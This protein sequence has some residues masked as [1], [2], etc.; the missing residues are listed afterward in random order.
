MKFGTLLVFIILS[1]SLFSQSFNMVTDIQIA[2]K[3]SEYGESIVFQDNLY[4]VGYKNAVGYCLFKT[5]GEARPSMVYNFGEIKITN[6]AQNSNYLVFLK[7]DE[8]W[9]TDGTTLGTE[10]VL[11]LLFPFSNRFLFQNDQALFITNLASGFQ[12]INRLDLTSNDTL[13]L[14]STQNLRSVKAIGEIDE[15]TFYAGYFGDFGYE[16]F[17]NSVGSDSL[18]LLKDISPGIANG[19]DGNTHMAKFDNKIFFIGKSIEYGNE[20][21]VTN[22]TEAGTYMLKDLYSG[23]GS[24]N[25]I[26]SQMFSVNNGIVF[27]ASN[28]I[29][30]SDGTVEGT[31]L[32]A[33]INVPIGAW[34]KGGDRIFINTG[35]NSNSY[36][37]IASAAGTY[38]KRMG[39]RISEITF[40]ENKYIYSSLNESPKG[41]ELFKFEEGTVSLLENIN[42]EPNGRIGSSQN[43]SFP[44]QFREVNGNLL[45]L[46][47]D[48]FNGTEL[49][50]TKNDSTYLFFELNKD[51]IQTPSSEPTGFFE[52][53]GFIYF[54]AFEKE[55]TVK[56][57]FKTNPEN[58]ETVKVLETANPIDQIVLLNNRIYINASYER[59][60]SDIGGDSFSA[61]D[62]SNVLYAASNIKKD[63]VFST[64]NTISKISPDLQVTH[65][66]TFEAGNEVTKGS[67]YLVNAQGNY[68]VAAE[69]NA[70]GRELYKLNLETLSIELVKDISAGG[71][72]TNIID[73]KAFNSNVLFV[74]ELDYYTRE[75]WFSDG[76]ELGTNRIGTYSYGYGAPISLENNAILG[77]FFYFSANFSNMGFELLKTD[78]TF[79]NTVLVSD[80]A[81]GECSSSDPGNFF[82][83]NGDLFFEAR[84]GCNFRLFKINQN[85]PESIIS[86]S[87]KPYLSFTYLPWDVRTIGKMDSRNVIFN[88]SDGSQGVSG[89]ELWVSDGTKEGTKL[90]YDLR[91]GPGNSNPSGFFRFENKMFFSANANSKGFE[92]WVLTLPNCPDDLLI[93]SNLTTDLISNSNYSTVIESKLTENLSSEVFIYS[94]GSILLKPGFETENFKIFKAAITSC[95]N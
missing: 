46:A 3:D 90:F 40:F 57:L 59:L 92:P 22:G 7:E 50:K 76:T 37:Y 18:F 44:K 36:V 71:A 65:F 81:N 70:Y 94:N 56:S 69:T 11:K 51:T 58:Y 14:K 72:N 53:N 68:F 26:G 80:M 82:F 64:Y 23:A 91:S 29:F 95:P 87:E 38:G 66:T 30:G 8:L 17:Y 25:Y 20:L 83:N 84:V 12:S 52:F 43:S 15:K 73:I 5:D 61:V 88:A 49:W 85:Y 78:G 67:K 32:L 31:K 10:K 28:S 33:S 77:D 74:V 63:S 39:N 62:P 47:T 55:G 42:K 24:Y 41:S 60:I 34:R 79:E 93:N 2:E 27:R 1:N 48:G 35:Y 89:Y 6:L 21:W 16:I 45:F 86:L 9:K 75:L 19:L 4:F 54:Q 13:T